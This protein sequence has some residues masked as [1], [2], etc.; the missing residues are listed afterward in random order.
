MELTAAAAP[1]FLPFVVPIC[2]WVAFSDMKLMKIPNLAV[3]CLIAVYLVV[4]L[5]ALPLDEYLWRILN[6]V[7]VLAVGF[8]LNMAR[9]LGA[10]DAKF[11]AAAAPFFAASEATTVVIFFAAIL[12]AAFATH[13]LARRIGFIRRAVPDWKSW[14]STK[15]PMGLALATTLAGYLALIAWVF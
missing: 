15:F 7:V 1:Y 4:G 11:A 12:L 10:G 2:V 9:A 5:F 3:L 13:R 8:V 6:G 14:E